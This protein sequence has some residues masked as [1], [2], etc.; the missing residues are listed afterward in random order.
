MHQKHVADVLMKQLTMLG[1]NSSLH[2]FFD[3]AGAS[4]QISR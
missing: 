3:S 2:F 4:P 1:I